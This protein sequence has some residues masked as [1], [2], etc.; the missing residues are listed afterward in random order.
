MIPD[1]N[2]NRKKR[3]IAPGI[4]E[5]MNGQSHISVPEVLAHLGLPITAENREMVKRFAVEP[6]L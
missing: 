6:K 4:W 2:T 3:D 1:A 5:D